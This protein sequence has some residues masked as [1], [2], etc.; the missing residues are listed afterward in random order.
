[1]KGKPKES[2]KPNYDHWSEVDGVELWEAIHLF[3]DVEPERVIVQYNYDENDSYRYKDIE[4]QFD[5]E[6]FDL[7]ELAKRAVESG[8]F[9]SYKGI[10]LR[11]FFEWAKK[12]GFPKGGRPY[13][14]KLFDRINDNLLDKEPDL[15]RQDLSP[16]KHEVINGYVFKRN[17]GGTWDFAFNGENHPAVPEK[18]GYLYIKTL[19]SV[20]NEDVKC[21]DL[22]DLFG[23]RTDNEGGEDIENIESYEIT[24]SI[25]SS[26]KRRNIGSSDNKMDNILKKITTLKEK[27][28]NRKITGNSGEINKLNKEMDSLASEYIRISRHSA[29]NNEPET[30]QAEQ[31]RKAVQKTIKRAIDHIKKL[32]PTLGNYLDIHIKTGMYCTYRTEDTIEWNLY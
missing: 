16:N 19:L 12:K 31:S 32:F 10:N 14:E 8:I 1:M 29:K 7:Y 27:I 4:S 3:Y 21:F 17:K 5:Q 6:Q 18:L 13:S 2:K 22:D 11:N 24:K 30:I 28:E 20:K 9:K 25:F 26:P 15:K 23:Q